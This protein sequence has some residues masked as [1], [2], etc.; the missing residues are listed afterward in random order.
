MKSEI[1]KIN[2]NAIKCLIC[3][4]QVTTSAPNNLIKSFNCKCDCVILIETK[5]ESLNGGKYFVDNNYLFQI[6]YLDSICSRVGD[7]VHSYYVEDLSI[8]NRFVSWQ[9]AINYIRGSLG[10]SSLSI[11]PNVQ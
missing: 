6:H 8:N 1:I 3:G 10:L 9:T 5:L 7:E 2:N 11:L 4:T